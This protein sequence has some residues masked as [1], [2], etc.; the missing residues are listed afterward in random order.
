MN[1]SVMSKTACALAAALTLAFAPLAIAPAQAAAP[2]VKTQAPGYYRM[3]LGSFEITALNDGFFDLP[4]DKLLKQPAARTDAA[5]AKHFQSCLLYT[6]P[7]P[8][9]S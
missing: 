8:R 7:S 1:H 6:S 4:V 2:Q 5:L 9:D 3:M